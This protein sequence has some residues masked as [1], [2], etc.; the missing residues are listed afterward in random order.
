MRVYVDFDDVLCE[1]A[2]TLSRLAGEMF[3]RDVP[4]ERITRF[5]LQLAFRLDESQIDALMR[6]AHEP[7]FLL[8]LP[9]APGAEEGLR[10]IA[11]AGHTVCIV[12]GRP[13]STEAASR[14]WLERHGLPAFE[15][16]SVDKYGRAKGE[17]TP[18]GRRALTPGEFAAIPFDAAVEDAP[19]ALDLLAS[20][21]RCRVFVFDR[22]WNAGY[23]LAANMERAAG[24]GAVSICLA[25]DSAPA[26]RE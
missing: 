18:D 13:A 1:T 4:Y 15:I 22:P 10:R 5:N 23:P 21:A 26:P 12:T 8:A 3:G 14:G 11:A 24:W 16:L 9:P 6:R 20:R 25:G 19:D 7:G 17:R 2:R